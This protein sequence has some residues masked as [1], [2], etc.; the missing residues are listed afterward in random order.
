MRDFKILDQPP[1]KGNS[2]TK[3]MKYI[4]YTDNILH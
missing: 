3:K 2:E 1:L 4:H